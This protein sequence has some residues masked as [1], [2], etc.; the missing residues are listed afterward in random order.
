MLALLGKAM[1]AIFEH[2]LIK[3]SPDI[4]KYLTN[5]LNDLSSYLE[6]YLDKKFGLAEAGNLP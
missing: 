2:E 1:I 4:Q 6:E 3:Q 5:E